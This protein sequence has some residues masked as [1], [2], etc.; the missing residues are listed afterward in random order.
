MERLRPVVGCDHIRVGVA[1]TLPR[2]VF[3]S[4]GRDIVDCESWSREQERQVEVTPRR[5]P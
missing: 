5:S 3:A 2:G 1:D 4:V